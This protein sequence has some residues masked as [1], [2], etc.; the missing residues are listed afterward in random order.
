MTEPCVLG[1]RR[2]K[3][4]DERGLKARVLR[5]GRLHFVCAGEEET[6]FEE[7]LSRVEEMARAKEV[8]MDV[9][10]LLPAVMHGG[11]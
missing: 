5:N 1:K 6:G 9:L 8:E 4:C 3:I 7:Q 11:N 10:P 2:G